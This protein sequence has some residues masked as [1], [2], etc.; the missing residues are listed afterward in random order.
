MEI[1]AVIKKRC[2]NGLNEGSVSSAVEE[3]LAL[4]FIEG[5]ESTA[6]GNCLHECYEEKVES[7][8]KS[9]V[10]PLIDWEDRA[11][12]NRDRALKKR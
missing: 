1:T 11:A 5:E 6:F 7:K 2:T 4:Q 12:S 8:H 3:V 9:A 10:S